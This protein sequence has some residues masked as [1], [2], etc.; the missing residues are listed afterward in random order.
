MSSLAS[1]KLVDI[2]RE[3]LEDDEFMSDP[4]NALFATLLYG[5][6]PAGDRGARY[7]KLI[8][9]HGDHLVVRQMVR[10]VA[11]LA[12]Y[13]EHMPL[14]EE[15][16]FEHTLVDIAMLERPASG[17]RQDAEARAYLHSDLQKRH[18]VAKQGDQPA[19][20]GLA[21]IEVDEVNGDTE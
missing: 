8:G 3:A 12:Y 11:L 16:A 21:A 5:N 2:V 7:E 14:A 13:R 6:L 9:L 4:A 1:V 20:A 10:Q 17:V 15:R 18:I 19:V